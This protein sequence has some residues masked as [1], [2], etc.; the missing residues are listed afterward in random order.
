MNIFALCGF[1]VCAVCV[2]LVLKNS[3][4]RMAPLAAAAAGAVMLVYTV[5][6]ASPVFA[7]AQSIAGESGMSAYF[8]LILKSLGIAVVCQLASEIC[9][10]LGENAMGGRIELAGKVAILLVSLPVIR[11]VFEYIKELV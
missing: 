5:N 4:S 9:R 10:D 2:T 3:E 7:L 8:A 11:R 6:N 1:G